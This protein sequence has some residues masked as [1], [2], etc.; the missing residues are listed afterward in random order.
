M[1]MS[2]IPDR[3]LRTLAKAKKVKGIHGRDMKEIAELIIKEGYESEIN[4]LAK[5]FAFTKNMGG[6]TIDRPLLKFPEDLNTPEKFIRSL[7]E[8]EMIPVDGVKKINWETRYEADLKIC[9]ILHDGDTV[10]I[11]TVQKRTTNRKKGWNNVV[12][13]EY[14]YIVPLAI[15]FGNEF[16]EYR[17]SLTQLGKFEAFVYRLL[18]LK[19]DVQCERLT[20]VTKTEAEAIKTYLQA[21]FS[22][23]HIGLPS[24]L[25]SIKFHSSRGSVD[26]ANDEVTGKIKEFIKEL[27][28]PTD[29]T[30]D[31][32][33]HIEEFKEGFSGILFPVTFEI[34]L[35]TGGIKFTSHHITQSVIDHI[36]DAI[37]Q[38]CFIRKQTK[39]DEVEAV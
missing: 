30:L 36:F 9:G 15:H 2:Y 14:A 6:F 5:Q 33:C 22:S 1:D 12:V 4:Y 7:V 24:T 10:F 18:N 3:I 20:K 39:E 34:N 37:I 17:C 8:R 23:E 35:K 21:G 11:N 25:G 31:V 32:T 28:L 26:L 13:D 38:V 29:D 16:I 27:D 19:E